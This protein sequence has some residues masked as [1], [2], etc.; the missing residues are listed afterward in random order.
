VRYLAN[1]ADSKG[2]LS[3]DDVVKLLGRQPDFEVVSDG[4]L[5]LEANNRGEPFITL[6][7]KA[8]ASGDVTSI[9]KTLAR[10]MAEAH[11]AAADKAARRSHEATD[12][13]S[14]AHP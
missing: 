14:A 5:V 7:P 12:Q 13:T 6:G 1:R 11:R 10:S 2:G 3:P 8:Q 9:A 4:M